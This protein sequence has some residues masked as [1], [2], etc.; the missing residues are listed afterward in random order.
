MKG[1]KGDRS[2]AECSEKRC[3]EV[4]CR[5]QVV[6]NSTHIVDVAKRKMK[7]QPAELQLLE[8]TIE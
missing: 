1:L 2:V 6:D 8:K 4:A 3:N 5:Q 7:T